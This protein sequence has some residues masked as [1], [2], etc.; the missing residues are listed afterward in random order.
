MKHF[1]LSI[2]L[3]SSHALAE[4]YCTSILRTHNVFNIK[5]FEDVRPPFKEA[6]ALSD[7][8]QQLMDDFL[9]MGEL[10]T[11][12]YRYGEN[13]RLFM[14]DLDP[15]KLEAFKNDFTDLLTRKFPNY[16]GVVFRSIKIERPDGFPSIGW[17]SELL[18]KD[19]RKKVLNLQKGSTLV[20]ETI[21]SSS[22]L[23]RVA[24]F[25]DGG[26]TEERVIFVIKIKN[27]IDLSNHAGTEAVNFGSDFP[28]EVPSHE[29]LILPTSEFE[30][31]EVLRSND[32]AVQSVV[33]L[34]ER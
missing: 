30:V 33:V 13:E 29:V 26:P 23:Y 15:I 12:Y 28:R 4:L 11:E 10:M 17:P 5:E 21:W 20:A 27:G 31:T 34:E 19:Y 7:Y 22:K 18:W 8:E 32:S 16:E 2:L 6:E 3:L 24:R 25:F 1:S 14:N 9:Y